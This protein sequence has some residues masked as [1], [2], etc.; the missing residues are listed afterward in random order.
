MIRVHLVFDVKHDRRHNARLVA[1]GPLTEVPVNSVYFG[2]VSLRGLRLMIFLG[3]L[4]IFEI[5]A[6]DIGN[7]SLETKT[8]QRLHIIAGPEFGKLEGHILVIY[9][10]QYGRRTSGLCWHE[11]FAD[12]LRQEGFEPCKAEPDIWMRPNGDVTNILLYMLTI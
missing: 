2:V 4:N 9:K 11:R 6:T 8:Q 12:C 3:E 10:A 7:A 5:W 1:D